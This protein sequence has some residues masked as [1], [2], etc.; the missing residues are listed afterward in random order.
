MLF[1]V[2]LIYWDMVD[3]CGIGIPLGYGYGSI[4]II[5]SFLGEWTSIYQLFWCSPGVQ[6][7]DTLPYGDPAKSSVWRVPS[8]Y[9]DMQR[10]MAVGVVPNHSRQQRLQSSFKKAAIGIH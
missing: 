3:R 4:P 2:D 7:F 8:S 1:N 10:S 6:G 5:I 9:R